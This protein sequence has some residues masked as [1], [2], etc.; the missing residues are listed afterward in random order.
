M[1]GCRTAHKLQ[2]HLRV[3]SRATA[4]SRCTLEGHSKGYCTKQVSTRLPTCCKHAPGCYKGLRHWT[5]VCRTARKTSSMA[6]D[7][8]ELCQLFTH[9]HGTACLS[10]L[11][12]FKRPQSNQIMQALCLPEFPDPLKRSTQQQSKGKNYRCLSADGSRIST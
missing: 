8:T 3:I 1:S 7:T 9:A 12:V 10:A 5:G 4:L 2:A 6:Q 11:S